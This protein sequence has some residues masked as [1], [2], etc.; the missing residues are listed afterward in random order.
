MSSLFPHLPL[1][2]RTAQHFQAQV[3]PLW[4]FPPLWNLEL[5][6]PHPLLSSGAEAGGSELYKVNIQS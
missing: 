3:Q 2:E 6:I 5:P 1:G 4:W